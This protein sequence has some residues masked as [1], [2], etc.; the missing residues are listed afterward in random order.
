[1]AALLPPSLSNSLLFLI[2]MMISIK[3][4]R[5]GIIPNSL[6]GM[7]AILGLLQ[8]G[9]SYWMSAAMLGLVA[10]GLYKLYPVLKNEEWLGFGDVKLM[11]VSGLWLDVSQ[12][13]LYLMMGG[14]IGIGI[15]IFWRILKKEQLF[16][17]GPALALAL[18]I[19]I[20]SDNALSLGENK[21]GY[22]VL[23]SQPSPSVRT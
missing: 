17:L 2:L 12:I 7:I 16:P 11:I 9:T 3:D 10:Y 18:G 19:C 4:L 20:V 6:L 13:P 8:F 22:N 15:G 21:N 1:M 23:I 14:G 5:S